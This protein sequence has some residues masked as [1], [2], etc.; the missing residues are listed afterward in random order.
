MQGETD[1]LK[2]AASQKITPLMKLGVPCRIYLLTYLLIYSMEQSPSREG[3]HFSASQ[4]IPRILRNP[5]V[6]YRIHQCPRPV[7]T[8]R[9]I[10]PVQVPTFQFLM[11]HLIILTP[12]SESSKWSLSLRFPHQNPVCAS[13]LP[14]TCYMPRPSHSSRVDHPNNIW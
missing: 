1:K 9:P 12:M 13:P 11:I 14:H 10:N 7:P 3:N 5:K 2:S 4:E 6:H 8:L